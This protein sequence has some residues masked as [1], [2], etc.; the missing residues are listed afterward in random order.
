M[1]GISLC[2]AC[3][4]GDHRRGWANPST[5]VVHF[6]ERRVIRSTLRTFLK[7]VGAI[8]HSHNRGQPRWQLLYEQNRYAY[9]T[10]YHKL[11]ITIPSQLA[12]L[13]RAMAAASAPKETHTGF[14]EWTRRRNQ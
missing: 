8:I 4:G 6:S 10:A 5:G 2:T 12:D 11:S 7:L 9:T 1:V 3:A 14:K 13:D